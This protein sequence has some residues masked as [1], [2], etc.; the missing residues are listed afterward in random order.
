MFCLRYI[1]LIKEIDN[2]TLLFIFDE[3]EYK[4]N[5]HVKLEDEINFNEAKN[6]LVNGINNSIILEFSAISS[7]I[8]NQINEF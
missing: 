5:I 2:F 6:N 8:N 7:F 1:N 3:N 4:Y